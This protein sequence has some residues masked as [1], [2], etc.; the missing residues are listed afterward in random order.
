MGSTP[1]QHA[2]AILQEKMPNDHDLGARQLGECPE[3]PVVLRRAGSAIRTYR[4]R[5]AVRPQQRAGLS[6]DES[7]RTR[8]DTRRRR[9]RAVGIALDPALSGTA[10]RA[11]IE[12][13]LSL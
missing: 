9:L 11:A 1:Q 6:G 5:H 8:S 3:S 12:P 4:C 2:A 7:D 10:I 13:A